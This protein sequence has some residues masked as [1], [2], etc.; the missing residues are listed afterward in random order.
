MHWGDGGSYDA[1]LA[2]GT[3]EVATAIDVRHPHMYVDQTPELE[4]IAR[5]REMTASF[6]AYGCPA[7]SH[8]AET[9]AMTARTAMTRPIATNSS[10]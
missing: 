3:Q 9:A 2:A 7:W 10:P 5:R 1:E 8:S 4:A 6:D